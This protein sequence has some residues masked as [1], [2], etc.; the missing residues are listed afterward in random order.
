MLS[1][2]RYIFSAVK[3]LL[4]LVLSSACNGN[5]SKVVVEIDGEVYQSRNFDNGYE[6]EPMWFLDFSTNVISFSLRKEDSNNLYLLNLLIDEIALLEKSYESIDFKI[7]ENGIIR[8]VEVKFLQPHP[9]RIY[10][11]NDDFKLTITSLETIPYQLSGNFSGTL[12]L[13]SKTGE[14]EEIKI[15]GEFSNVFFSEAFSSLNSTLR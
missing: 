14:F 2:K 3:F 8:K 15:K 6:H 12:M 7:H 4:L 5:D 10:K 11:V 13:E 1:S 9:R